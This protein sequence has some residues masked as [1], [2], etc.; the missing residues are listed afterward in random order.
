[1]FQVGRDT[2]RDKLTTLF[3]HYDELKEEIESNYQLKYYSINI[4]S[5]N[6]P[7]PITSEFINT[8]RKVARY[9]SYVICLLMLVF[10]VVDHDTIEKASYFNFFHYYEKMM[11]RILSTIQLLLTMTFFT[12]WIKMRYKLCISKL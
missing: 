3:D 12:L 1:M 2:R 10:I 8:I 6:F 4:G 9:V 11:M 5:F 7:I